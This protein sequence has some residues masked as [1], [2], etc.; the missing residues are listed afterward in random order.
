MIERALDK[1]SLEHLLEKLMEST[2]ELLTMLKRL[3]EN[4]DIKEKIK[5]IQLI[6]SFIVVKGTESQPSK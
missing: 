4:T 2:D 3:G 1:M 5:E 6:Q